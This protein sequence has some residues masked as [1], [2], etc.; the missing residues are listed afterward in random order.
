VP[1]VLDRRGPDIVLC[2]Q[3]SVRI[4]IGEETVDLEQGA[5]VFAA[6]CEGPTLTLAGSGVAFRATVGA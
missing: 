2:T 6:A 3:G 4:T 5:S 1:T